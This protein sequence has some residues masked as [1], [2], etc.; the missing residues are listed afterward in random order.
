MFLPKNA[1]NR[2]LKDFRES[3]IYQTISNHEMERTLHKIWKNT[4]KMKKILN[5]REKILKVME[6]K[7]KNWKYM[8]KLKFHFLLNFIKLNRYDLIIKKYLI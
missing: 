5:H 7:K 1:E 4:Q 2:K 8:C 6:K 3:Q